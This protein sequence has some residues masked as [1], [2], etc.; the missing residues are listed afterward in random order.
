MHIWIDGQC[1]QTTSADRGI[2]RYVFNFTKALAKHRLKPRISVSLN[3]AMPDEFIRGSEQLKLIVPKIEVLSW[4]GIAKLGEVYDHFS[5]ERKLSEVALAHHVAC[6]A[7]DIAISSSLLEGA[8]D[9]AVP[10]ISN[11]GHAFPIAAIFYDAIPHK[12]PDRY[13]VNKDHESYYRRRLGA[14]SGF[15]AA[16]GI[17]QFAT[18][19]IE[20]LFPTLDANEIGAG[21]S[22]HFQ[23]KALPLNR[24][25]DSIFKN[26]KPYLLYV[27]SMDWRKNVSAVVDAFSLLSIE[28][29]TKL[30]F[31]VAGAYDEYNA[32]QLKK[33]WQARGLDTENLIM[34]GQVSD[35]Q[36]TELYIHATI[37]IQPSI[38]EGF[39]LTALESIM[40]GTPVIGSKTGAL[41]E[42]LSDP[43]A[44]FDPENPSDIAAKIEEFI[45]DNKFSQSVT[46]LQ[47][48]HASRFTWERTANLAMKSIEGTIRKFR[49]KQKQ[50]N[51]NF[52]QEIDQIRKTTR[53]ALNTKS[54]KG[55][56][57]ARLMAAAEPK[58]QSAAKIYIDVTSTS[59]MKYTS[60]IQRVVRKIAAECVS[61][62]ATDDNVDYILWTSEKKGEI[63]KAN[64]SEKE[65]LFSSVKGGSFTF[66]FSNKDVLLMLDSSW[67][68]ISV[69]QSIQKKA[70]VAGAQ[71]ISCLYDNVPIKF[72]AMCYAETSIFYTRW[73]ESALSVSTGFVCI[74]RTVADEFLQLLRAIEFPRPMKVGYWMLGADFKL[75]KQSSSRLVGNNQTAKKYLAVGTLEPRKNHI[76]V[77]E[78]FTDLWNNGFEGTLTLVARRGWSDDHIVEIIESHNELGKKLTWHKSATDEKLIE[79]YSSSDVVI[80]ASHAEG[81][82]LPIVESLQYG[83][84]IL[85]SDIPVFREV[86]GNHTGVRYFA[87]NSKE[88]LMKEILKERPASLGNKK[89][90]TLRTI[91]WKKSKEQL[92]EVIVDDNWYQEYIPSDDALQHFNRL[93]NVNVLKK[94]SAEESEHQIELV[95]SA[96]RLDKGKVLKYT[97]KVT[98]LSS[99]IFSS[100]GA[101]DGSLGIYLSYHIVSD[102]GE[103]LRFDNPRSAI[104]FVI[105]PNDSV[106]LAVD[107]DVKNLPKNASYIDLEM[108]QET[109]GWW[110]NTLRVALLHSR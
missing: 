10:L 87:T 54:M 51:N 83:C 61:H 98:N 1:L 89:Q 57:V 13:L 14:Y 26:F 29:K 109:V 93:G 104:P 22:D 105:P 63:T 48:S 52:N 67:T 25:S 27:G 58:E 90:K 82:G 108:V 66:S 37:S 74:S 102:K 88:S 99:T 46:K 3:A 65:L 73:L 44:M 36:L 110:G 31:L 97:V 60:G 7:P 49:E 41:P 64:I 56:I 32:T 42:V 21:F 5:D 33:K 96:A 86:A 4:Q 9:R 53:S 40:C 79:E 91:D 24:S 8:G 100:R 35:K 39:G 70:R 20:E 34:V 84:E 107:I 16:L 85:A 2:G 68:Y 103:M 78:A 62:N 12:F 23:S 75:S 92:L 77:L 94:L 15:H 11:F 55:E 45:S 95:G 59:K 47:L 76:L 18:N 19:Q 72:P 106:Y 50:T 30:N 17:S 28:R 38:M 81:F 101:S 43:R 71:V 80:A 6:L 69:H